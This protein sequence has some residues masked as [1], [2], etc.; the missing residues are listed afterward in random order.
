[1]GQVDRQIPFLLFLRINGDLLDF[2]SGDRSHHPHLGR[3]G[4]ALVLRLQ[5]HRQVQRPPQHGLQNH[6]IGARGPDHPG[7]LG[8]FLLGPGQDFRSV[9]QFGFFL[10]PSEGVGF[11]FQH[12]FGHRLF[13][14]LDLGCGVGRP[15]RSGNRLG[16]LFQG[17]HAGGGPG[18]LF[19][20]LLDGILDRGE[21]LGRKTLLRLLGRS[22]LEFHLRLLENLLGLRGLLF[23][24]VFLSFFPSPPSL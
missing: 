12:G 16:F 2:R 4:E 22:C 17:T 19:G 6:G 7:K 8:G 13:A 11:E 20:G 3:G 23:T 21:L 15:E 14:L 5:G 24:Q 10:L 18:H 9:V 1:M